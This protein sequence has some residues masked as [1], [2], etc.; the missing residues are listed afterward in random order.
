MRILVVDDEPVARARIVRML[1]RIA[2]AE[3]VGEAG[4][5]VDALALVEALRPDVLLLDIDMPGLDGL[6]VAQRPGIPPVIFT[7]AHPEHAL[8]A[9]EASAFD[10]LLKPIAEDRLAR[11]LARVTARARPTHDAWRVVVTDGPLKRFVDARTIDCFRADRKYVAFDLAGE[12]LL[13]RES[14]DALEARLTPCGFLRV[15]RSA[16]V[17]RG[18]I[19]GLDAAAGAVVLDSGARVPVSRRATAA[20]RAALGLG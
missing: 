9:F 18:A 2:E 4:D 8:E 15:S 19:T 13:S 11:G 20:V 10:Y 16:L 5:G 3:V 6:A 12:E 14:L 7:T 1:G 17:R